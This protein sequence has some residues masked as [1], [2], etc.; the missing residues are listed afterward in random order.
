MTFE[1]LTLQGIDQKQLK[2]IIAALESFSLYLT[3]VLAVCIAIAA[4]IVYK[5]NKDGMQQFV[6]KT[7]DVV[8]G[9]SVSLVAVFLF[10]NISRSIL[11]KEILTPYYWFLAFAAVGAILL[12]VGYVLNKK[13][14]SASKIYNICATCAMAVFAL[15][16]IIFIKVADSDYTP[17]NNVLF[18]FLS[19]ILCV[20]IFGGAFLFNKDSENNAKY[21]TYAGVCIATSYALSFVKFLQMPQGGSVTLASMLPL[22]LFAYKFGTK[23]GVLAGFVYGL[24]QLIQNPVIYH[25]LQ[26]FMDYMVAFS[27]LGLTGMFRKFNFLK[28]NDVAKFALGAFVAGT[29]RYLCHVVTGIFVFYTWAQEGYTAVA[30]GFVYNS[31][32]FVDLAIV[33]VVG[34]LVLLNKSFKNRFLYND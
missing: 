8:L 11:K 5:T 29:L 30:W 18:Y 15:L 27:A 28:D 13:R 32:V 14:P 4:V 20:V 16:L 17:S 26:V 12:A 2:L 1:K 34:C 19:A 9:Y 31:F 23:K 25:P 3:I 22:M 6:K 10:L 24:L 33:L 21:V 7:I